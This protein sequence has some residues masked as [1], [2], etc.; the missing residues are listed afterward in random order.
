MEYTDEFGNTQTLDET[1]DY[2]IRE[3]GEIYDSDGNYVG[4]C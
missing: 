2:D 1:E 3:D 4:H